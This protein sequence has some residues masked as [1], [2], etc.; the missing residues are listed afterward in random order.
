VGINALRARQKRNFI[1]TLLL[2]QGVPMLLAGD[3][4]GRTQRGNNNAYCQDNEISW[5]DWNLDENARALLLLFQRLIQ[6]RRQHPVFRRRRF[7]Q[8]RPIRGG[9]VK[10]LAWLTPEGREMDDNEWSQDFAR[11]LGVYFAGEALEEADRRGHPVRDDNFLLLL[12][13]H[14]ESIAFALPEFRHGSTWQVLLDTAYEQGLAMD[15]R[16]PGAVRYDLQ[17]RSLA[18]FTEIPLA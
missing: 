15:G 18:L 2:S 16:F 17:G 1:S 7:F 4:I 11:S 14:H 8:G 12:N 10:D 9:E 3:E 13:A 5:L 6:I